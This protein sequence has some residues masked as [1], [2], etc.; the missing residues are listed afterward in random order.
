MVSKNKSES[1]PEIKLEKYHLMN[2][3]SGQV[4]LKFWK[5][6]KYKKLSDRPR[7]T[8]RDGNILHK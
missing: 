4:W 2:K 3:Q 1:G 8:E 6:L 5:R 7:W